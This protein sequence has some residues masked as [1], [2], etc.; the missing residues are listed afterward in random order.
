MLLHNSRHPIMC[1][2]SQFFQGA[3]Y[4]ICVSMKFVF[5]ENWFHGL[6]EL[7]KY[8]Q[9][10]SILCYDTIHGSLH[11]WPKSQFFQ[12]ANCKICVPTKLGYWENWLCGL[13]ELIKYIQKYLCY[14]IIRSKE[15]TKEP[16]KSVFSKAGYN[17]CALAKFGFW[18][19]WLCELIELI[20]YIQKHLCYFI[21]QF[22]VPDAY[23]RKPSFLRRLAVKF[24]FWRSLNF[25]KMDL[26]SS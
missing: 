20:E 7:I 18:E 10:I 9:K 14:I 24:M 23:A 15:P 2:K 22:T 4:K 17:I 8:K 11:M 16:K 21:I 6:V 26:A 5:W 12:G 1:W 19:N 13:I 3:S 25:K